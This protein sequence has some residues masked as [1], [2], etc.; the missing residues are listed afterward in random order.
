MAGMV[1]DRSILVTG[2]ASGIGR[3]TALVLAREGARVTIADRDTAGGEATLAMLREIGA[4]AIFVPVDVAN[5]ASVAAMVQAAVAAFGRLD[6]AFNNAGI[7]PQHAGPAGLPLAHLSLDAFQA[8]IDINLTGV[9]L[10]L[11]YE[12]TQM[13]TQPTQA[14]IVNTA[15]IAG[16]KGLPTAASYTA[17]KHGVIGLTRTAAMEYA[18]AGI[19]VNAVC[20]GFIDTQMVAAAGERAEKWKKLVPLRRLGKPEEVSEAVL[21]LLSDRASFVTGAAWTID[22]GLTA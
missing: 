11:K 8:M 5:E 3:D 4:E 13:L 12:I 21:W 16:L 20:P 9:F 17:A 1:E 18:R 22:G 2:G 7:G 15:S 19:R 14:A 10:C 6:G